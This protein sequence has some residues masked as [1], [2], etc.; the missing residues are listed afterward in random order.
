MFTL[1][2]SETSIASIRRRSFI[3]HAHLH[4][5]SFPLSVVEWDVEDNDVD[6]DDDEDDDDDNDDDSD[7]EETLGTLRAKITNK[8]YTMY[9]IVERLC[10][11]V[12]I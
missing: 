9:I 7:D 3:P 2:E 11:R 8:K 4:G 1:A 6:D 12:T 5:S 10:F